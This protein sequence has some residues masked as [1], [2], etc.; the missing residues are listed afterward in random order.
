M[1]SR[2]SKA[3]TPRLLQVQRVQKRKTRKKSRRSAFRLL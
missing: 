1:N 3:E 2:L